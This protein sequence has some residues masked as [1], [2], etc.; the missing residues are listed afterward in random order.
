VTQYWQIGNGIPTNKFWALP[1]LYVLGFTIAYIKSTAGIVLVGI[2]KRK[3]YKNRP[4]RNE[5]TRNSKFSP[6]TKYV[7]YIVWKYNKTFC[8]KLKKK[9]NE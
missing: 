3:K 1:V 4:Y 2:G 7:V 5:G 6:Q 8:F 9:Q